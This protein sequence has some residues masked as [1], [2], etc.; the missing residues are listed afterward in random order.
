MDHAWILH[1]SYLMSF[2]T[3]TIRTFKMFFS[4]KDMF[5]AQKRHVCLSWT[6]QKVWP[7]LV[8]WTC[9]EPKIWPI[10]F[11]EH[12]HFWCLCSCFFMYDFPHDHP[13]PSREKTAYF[14]PPTTPR[15]ESA[16]AYAQHI[17]NALLTGD[18]IKESLE[19]LGLIVF[20]FFR[21][22]VKLEEKRLVEDR[23]KIAR[24]TLSIHQKD[25]I[26]KTKIPIN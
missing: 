18:N 8:D 26:K 3:I 19:T 11:N 17:S 4:A 15:K 22:G 6:Q 23:S 20:F 10:S 2:F 25:N 9:H 16:F 12:F 14:H 1:G 21:L 13:P 5:V 24:W 7:S